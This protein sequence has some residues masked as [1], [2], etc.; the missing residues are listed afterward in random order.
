MLYID[1]SN[2]RVL[3]EGYQ[4]QKGDIVEFRTNGDIEFCFIYTVEDSYLSSDPGTKEDAIFTFLIDYGYIEP[5]VNKTESI[6][7]FCANCYGYPVRCP[8]VSNIWPDFKIKDYKAATRIVLTIFE[9]LNT[10][11]I[12]NCLE[13]LELRTLP[14]ISF[15]C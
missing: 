5:L 12:Y 1:K 3:Q 11:P 15:L 6:H 9:L 2:Y 7:S 13:K 4:L 14:K 10:G 8:D